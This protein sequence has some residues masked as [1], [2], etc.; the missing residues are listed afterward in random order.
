MGAVGMRED[1]IALQD[2]KWYLIRG[3]WPTKLM[4]VNPPLWGWTLRHGSLVV[5]RVYL[6]RL[7]GDWRAHVNETMQFT[8]DAHQCIEWIWNR[9][10][11]LMPE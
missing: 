10:H 6:P 1:T 7:G 5:G 3:Q 2:G 11:E 9:R 8:G 4:A